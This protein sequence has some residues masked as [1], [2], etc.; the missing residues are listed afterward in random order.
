MLIAVLD[1]IRGS[2]EKYKLEIVAVDRE[3]AKQKVESWSREKGLTVKNVS[4]SSAALE[5]IETKKSYDPFYGAYGTERWEGV[6]FVERQ[7]TLDLESSFEQILFDS[8]SQRL[9]PPT[10]PETASEQSRRLLP[11]E[12]TF[13]SKVDFSSWILRYSSKVDVLSK[14]R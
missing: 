7:P 10:L 8:N 3:E 1:K 4:I 12:R 2:L 9:E 11:S 14:S 5:A 13:Q 6:V